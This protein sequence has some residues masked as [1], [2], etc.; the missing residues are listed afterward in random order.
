MSVAENTVFTQEQA[1]AEFL[2]CILAANKV[3]NKKT[4]VLAKV[5]L[6]GEHIVTI[7]GDGKETQNTAKPGDYIVQNMTTAKEQYIISAEKML[8]RYQKLADVVTEPGW[9]LW[10]AVG[11]V[12]GVEYTGPLV[13]IMATWGETMPLKPGDMVVTPD[14]NE[15]YRIARKEFEETYGG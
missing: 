15:I 1:K 7:T 8:K 12:R 6:G 11:Q 4:Q 2:P 5:A 9:E 3:Y 13:E 14:G 10:K